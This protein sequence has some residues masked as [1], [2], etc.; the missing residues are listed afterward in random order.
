MLTG[1]QLSAHLRLRSLVQSGW[2]KGQV[3]KGEATKSWGSH[4]EAATPTK[5]DLSWGR[6]TAP[7]AVPGVN[8]G[9][10]R[11]RRA[12]GVGRPAADSQAGDPAATPSP[13]PRG[14]P[15]T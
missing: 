15:G 3:C 6:R 13:S 12:A 11:P 2:A 5:I 10:G 8:V 9:W 1:F 7:A 14:R 4:K